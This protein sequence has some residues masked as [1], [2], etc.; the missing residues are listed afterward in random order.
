MKLY[1]ISEQSEIERV[2]VLSNQLKEAGIEPISLLPD[3]DFMAKGTAIST[4]LAVLLISS[5]TGAEIFNIANERNRKNLTTINYFA[6]GVALSDSQKIAIGRNRSVFAE[7]H[8]L[9]SANDILSLIDVDLLS[10]KTQVTFSNDN[11]DAVKSVPKMDSN[12][13]VQHINHT[14]G[15]TNEVDSEISLEE[16]KEKEEGYRP[17]KALMIMIGVILVTYIIEC[18]FEFRN[19]QI[20]PYIIYA[21]DFIITSSCLGGVDQYQKKNGKTF[22][23][24]LV[25]IIG[26]IFILIYVLITIINIYNWI[27]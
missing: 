5:K 1:I 7:L 11:T 16:S 12:A 20:L 21:I 24:Q 9:D 8:P 3:S 2:N 13:S 23:S 6:E 15:D 18:W 4:P 17:G 26:W 14:K 25:V 19:D 22:F 10:P 27:F